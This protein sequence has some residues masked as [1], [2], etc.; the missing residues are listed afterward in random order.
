MKDISGREYVRTMSDDAVD[1]FL[2]IASYYHQYGNFTMLQSV[3]WAKPEP[4]EENIDIFKTSLCAPQKGSCSCPFGSN[5][6]YGAKTKDG[7][8]Y[9]IDLT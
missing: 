9:N 4:L 8:I 3:N 2:D 1:Y 7:D 5:V 6:H